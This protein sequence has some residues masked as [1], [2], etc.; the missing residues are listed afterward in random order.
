MRSRYHANS[1]PSKSHILTDLGHRHFVQGRY[2]VF[3]HFVQ[4]DAMGIDSREIDHLQ[5]L[6]KLSRTRTL[7]MGTLFKID[8]Q[9][10]DDS[11]ETKRFSKTAGNP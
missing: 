10:P 7:S 5:I 3:G 1:E 11:S 9:Y 8:T 4:K 6:G 2:T